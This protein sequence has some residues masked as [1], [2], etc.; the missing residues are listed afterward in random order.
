MVSAGIN[1]AARQGVT[2]EHATGMA[3]HGTVERGRQP[4]DQRQSGGVGG[5]AEESAQPGGKI[6]SEAPQKAE[7][8]SVGR[9]KIIQS[10][11]SGKTTEKQDDDNDDWRFEIKR[12]KRTAGRKNSGSTA[13]ADWY[14]W[15]VR[16][17][18]STGAIVYYGTL[19]VL[20]AANPDRLRKYW[21]RS[22]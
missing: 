3:N 10:A 14:Y 6:Q 7:N 17:N 4:A 19:D 13:K 2:N 5:G 22:R 20:D 1:D 18:K 12:K 21:R 16:V 15:V 9:R 8:N 11:T